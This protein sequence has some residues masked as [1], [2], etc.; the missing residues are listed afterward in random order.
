ME[1]IGSQHAGSHFFLLEEQ[2]YF[3]SFAFSKK[4]F[5]ENK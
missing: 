3:R 4:L 2:L 1:E 5:Q